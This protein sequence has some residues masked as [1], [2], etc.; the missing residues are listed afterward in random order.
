M[1][2]HSAVL[3]IT[4][5]VECSFVAVHHSGWKWVVDIAFGVANGADRPRRPCHIIGGHRF[6]LG[7]SWHRVACGWED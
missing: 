3:A 1:E 5:S 2:Q 6:L 4:P 7:S